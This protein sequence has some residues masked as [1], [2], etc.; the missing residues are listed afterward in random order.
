LVAWDTVPLLLSRDALRRIL[1]EEALD[2]RGLFQDNVVAVAL[3]LDAQKVS[4]FTFVL[5]LPFL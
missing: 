5:D 4:Y 1:G 3:E 2:V